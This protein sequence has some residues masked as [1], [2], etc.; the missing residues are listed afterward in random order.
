M[1]DKVSEVRNE[2]R[3]GEKLRASNSSEELN[4]ILQKQKFI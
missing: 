3:E 4:G 1:Q 2:K